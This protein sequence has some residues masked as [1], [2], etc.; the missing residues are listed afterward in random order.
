MGFIFA[1]YEEGKIEINLSA[2][3]DHKLVDKY[4][5]KFASDSTPLGSTS[6]S[7]TNN[8]ITSQGLT[9][10]AGPNGIG[11]SNFLKVLRQCIVR[12]EN[13]TD[14]QYVVRL[15]EKECVCDSYDPY[16]QTHPLIKDDKIEN[17]YNHLK[18]SSS[19]EGVSSSKKP[20]LSTTPT[21]D[22]NQ[23][24][25]LKEK[26]EKNDFDLKSDSEFMKDR[27]KTFLKRQ[28][29]KQFSYG[30]LEQ[31]LSYDL[32]YDYELTCLNEYLN[33]NE[34]GLEFKYDI[35]PSVYDELEKKETSEI[36]NFK[37]RENDAT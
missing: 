15:L 33:N 36:V 6:A 26:I 28:F 1:I 32:P 27:I 12:Y 13:K 25:F 34:Y 9:I 2:I 10:I 19:E 14:L 37:N 8:S 4:N 22:E 24:K 18:E 31:M 21:L 23:I 3:N 5:L 35:F 29:A 20:K 11:K 17:I 7:P 30:N 16:K